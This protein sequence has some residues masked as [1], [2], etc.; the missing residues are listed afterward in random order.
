[1]QGLRVESLA[2][3]RRIDDVREQNRDDSTKSLRRLLLERLAT[4]KAK[5]A[6]SGF[7]FP[8]ALQVARIEPTQYVPRPCPIRSVSW[9]ASLPC[10]ASISSPASPV[11]CSL[12]WLKPRRRY[13]QRPGNCSSRR[14]RSRRT[15][16]RWSRAAFACTVVSRRSSSWE[17]HGELAALV[18]QPR[19]A[20]VTALEPTLVL[21][22][23]KAVLD[24]LLATGP[25]S[26][27]VRGGS[28]RSW[29]A[30]ARSPSMPPRRGEQQAAARRHRR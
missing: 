28:R 8:Q 16:T 9:S 4:G 3:A 20:S 30:W 17:R 19:T 7:S 27:T 12:L 1:M 13:A 2:Q 14:V 11:A 22:L 25:S 23:D 5:R 18:P 15:C 29:R 10:T 24:D 21:R 6:F 26:P